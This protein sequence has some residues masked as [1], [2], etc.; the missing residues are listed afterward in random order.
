MI[1]VVRN[2]IS[3]PLAA[4]TDAMAQLAAGNREVVVPESSRADEIGDLVKAFDVFR[5][6]TFALEEAHR[7]AEEA[8][9]REQALAR[10]DPLTGLTNRRVLEEELEKALARASRL[11]MSFAVLLIDLDR[12]KPI[13]DIHGHSAGDLVLVEIAARLKEVVRK[14]DTLSR[15]G[16]DEFA[17]VCDLESGSVA[18]SN[19]VILFAERVID[20]VRAPVSISGKQVDVDASIGIALR[21]DRREGP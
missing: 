6:N 7:L 13:N 4:I 14:S 16:G 11:G 18:D 17:I 12:F 5:G 10:H 19:G 2:N 1:I 8:H 20:A 15:I 21:A 9:L 3:R